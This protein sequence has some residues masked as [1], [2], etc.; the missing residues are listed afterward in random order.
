MPNINPSHPRCGLTQRTQR[1]ASIT[2]SECTG[3]AG[4]PHRRPTRPQSVTGRCAGAQSAR[5]L[6]IAGVFPVRAHSPRKPPRT[7]VLLPTLR[8]HRP[9]RCERRLQHC[10][11]RH[12]HGL[13]SRSDRQNREASR[14]TEV[15]DKD[16]AG[17]VRCA[18]Q[19]TVSPAKAQADRSR[20]SMKQEA[21]GT[22]SL[23]APTTAPQGV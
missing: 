8:L 5:R 16:R 2:I 20:R 19:S 14:Q 22:R 3:H 15:N 11:P 23:D 1:A 9:R 17:N 12:R 21:R 18:V 6:F 7:T 10:R 4:R 13:L